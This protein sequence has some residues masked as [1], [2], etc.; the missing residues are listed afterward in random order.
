MNY[1]ALS[2]PERAALPRS[3]RCAASIIAPMQPVRRRRDPP[4]APRTAGPQ[5][6]FGRW[7]RR[8]SPARQDRFATLGPLVSVLLFLAAIISAFWYLRNE[9]IEREQEAVKRDTEIAQQ[10]IRLRLIENQEQLVRIAREI[11][12]REHRRRTNSSAR[13]PSFTRERPEITSLVWLDADRAR[14]GE[15]LGHRP[16]RPSSRHRAT[17]PSLPARSAS[18]ASP[19][20]PS[21]PARDLRQPV[22]SRPSA[23]ATATPVFQIHVP[24]IDRG[25]V[26]RHADGRVLGREPAALLRAGRGVDTATPSRCSTTRTARWPAPSRRC[27]VPAVARARR[28]CTRC[29]WRPRATA[30]CCAA[31]ATAP[32]SA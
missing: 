23:T 28:S 15:L 8:Q 7:W 27:P 21:T 29:R 20:R 22:Y 2:S 10:Q 3:A 25:R 12:T 1:Q 4:R 24:L 26:R 5:R 11:G 30:W 31:R 16:S 19:K 13:P 32:R 9:E 6:L 14:Q 17:E 18:R